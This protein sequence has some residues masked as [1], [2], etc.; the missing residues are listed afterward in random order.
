MGKKPNFLVDENHEQMSFHIAGKCCVIQAQE[1][2]WN[3]TKILVKV[4]KFKS[5][6]AQELT[7]YQKG[8]YP[9]YSKNHGN[10]YLKFIFALI[11]CYIF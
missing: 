2:C 8:C 7:I 9:S 4:N 5:E 10:K 1:F 3:E 6:I 11:I